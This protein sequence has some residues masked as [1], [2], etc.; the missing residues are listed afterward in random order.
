MCFLELRL[1]RFSNYKVLILLGEKLDV[2][3]RVL[4]VLMMFVQNKH[5]MSK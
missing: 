2:F 5:F 3:G 4:V 1:F